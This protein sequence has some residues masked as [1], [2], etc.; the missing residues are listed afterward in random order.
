MLDGEDPLV[1]APPQ[2]TLL[3]NL[4]RGLAVTV[5]LG[6]F[7]V[8]IYAYSGAARRDA[9]DLISDGAFARTAEAICAE[10]QADIDAM[11]GAL[12]AVDGPDRARQIRATNVRYEA[13]LDEL[14]ELTP[15]LSASA[16]D[17][18]IATG[19]LADWRVIVSDRYDYADRIEVDDQAQF[20]LSNLGVS[21]RLDRRLTRLATTNLMP[22]CGA[23]TDVG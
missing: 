20:Y 5:V 3:G 19:W 13:M 17:T 12:D 23:P 7:L 10:A 18:E 2:R 21:E 8:W 4:G 1:E 22:S 15:S 11:P 9:P 6:S 14:D 16:R